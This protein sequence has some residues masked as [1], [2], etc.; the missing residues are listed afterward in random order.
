VP[1]IYE[2]PLKFH[3][4]GLDQLIVDSLGLNE[5]APHANLRE[6]QELVSTIK[7]PANGT[8]SIAIVGKYVELEDSYKSLREAL[9][10][11]GVANNLR[12]KV[13]WIESESLLTTIILKPDCK[14]LM[15]FSCLAVLA[16]AVL[17]V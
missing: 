9:T 8:V 4:Q 1:T 14:I 12:V 10:H 16:N 2:V 7:E 11:A 15:R 13:V 6:W 17:P 3:E 5:R